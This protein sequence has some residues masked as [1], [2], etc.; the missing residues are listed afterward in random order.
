MLNGIFFFGLLIVFATEK[1]SSRTSSI[2]SKK[3]LRSVR[4]LPGQQNPYSGYALPPGQNP[5]QGV[6]TAPA[7]NNG[8][9]SGYPYQPR[10]AGLNPGMSRGPPMKTHTLPPIPAAAF[11]DYIPPPIPYNPIPATPRLIQPYTAP[12]QRAAII[13]PVQLL[14][15]NMGY[16]SSILPSQQSPEMIKNQVGAV[17]QQQSTT[18]PQYEKMKHDANTG[19]YMA[20]LLTLPCIIGGCCIGK[21][22]FMPKQGLFYPEP[23]M[24]AQQP[25]HLSYPA[26]ASYVSNQRSSKSSLH[27]DVT[28]SQDH[29]GSSRNLESS[30]AYHNPVDPQFQDP[31]D[32]YYAT[33]GYD[34]PMYDYGGT[35]TEPK[36]RMNDVT[37]EGWDRVS[38]HK[39]GK[40]YLP[41][42][43]FDHDHCEFHSFESMTR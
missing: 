27:A 16:P 42:H 25:D 8:A 15:F 9:Q 4:L 26:G 28:N 18:S 2:Q 11:P 43:L 5:N 17:G 21:M 22:F 20:M 3:R 35:P 37:P 7:Y 23:L 33:T 38:D 31:H 24:Y 39:R 1:E 30:S 14:P 13:Q 32:P 12:P 34:D 36:Q 10:G 19:L 29:R 41:E 40:K 6:Y